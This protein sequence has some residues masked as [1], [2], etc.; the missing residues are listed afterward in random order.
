MSKSISL[1]VLFIGFI[2]FIMSCG[3]NEIAEPTPLGYEYYP[4]EIGSYL[5]YQVDSVI[6]DPD[7]GGTRKDSSSSQIK[8]VVVDSFRDASNAL[9]YR[10]ERYHRADENANWVIRN[11]FSKGIV[12]R[13]GIYVD[14]NL[15]FIKL[16]FPLREFKNWDGN[17]YFDEYLEVDVAGEPIQIFLDR[18]YE[19]EEVGIP[20]AE[21]DDVISVV[22]ARQDSVI[23]IDYYRYGQKQP[24]CTETDNTYYY[25]GDNECIDTSLHTN[26]IEYR[27]VI[28]KYA[29]NVGLVYRE[30][31]FMNA[32]C[33]KNSG[34]YIDPCDPFY[35]HCDVLPT[36]CDS[37]TW[38]EKAETGFIMTQRLIDYQ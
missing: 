14:D 28:E 25:L 32:Q 21:F 4:L 37:L 11:V 36:A 33:E 17:L 34:T 16:S 20:F 38:E 23:Q 27:S 8:E 7:I 30:M 12:D 26:P 15:R 9:M 29:R 35:T 22:S 13:K 10:I 2:F 18:T 24:R 3:K 5:V 31:K 1:F 19:I 6:F